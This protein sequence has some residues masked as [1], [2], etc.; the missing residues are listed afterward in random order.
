MECETAVL[1]E[2]ENIT[3]LA[4]RWRMVQPYL[5]HCDGGLDAHKRQS[6][7]D[8]R[9]ELIDGESPRLCDRGSVCFS[10]QGRRAGA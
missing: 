3:D 2:S 6:E 7:S 9:L 8:L 1:G 4:R 10:Q 5:L